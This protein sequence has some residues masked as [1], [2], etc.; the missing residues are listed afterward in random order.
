[1]NDIGF[2]ASA[3][4]GVAYLIEDSSERAVAEVQAA[5]VIAKK[6]P[7]NQF[8]A[9]EAIR[10]ACKRPLLA[11]QA[12]Y[13]YPRGGQMVE[14]AS[15]RLAEA[16]AQAWGNME[17]GIREISR[18]DG[19][20]IC[21]AYAI[22]YQSNMRDVK[23]FHVKHIR[24]TKKGPVAVKDERDIYELVANMGARRKRACILAVLPG[25]VVE[26]AIAQCKKTQESSEVP[27]AEQIR[28]M[29]AAFDEFGIKI[30]HLEKRLGHNLDA[31][32][33]TELVSLR[34]IYKSIK[35]GMADRSQFFDISNLTAVDAKSTIKELIDTKHKKV[36]APSTD[37]KK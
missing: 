26:A 35:D 29:V 20:S 31:T 36:E 6:F 8:E 11:E 9:F 1:M 32:I 14:G 24:D 25:D 12:L 7:R 3:P 33:P 4:T 16:L 17:C 21:E 22:D 37:D 15:I 18:S 23:T 10:A 28:S 5:F 19:V 27:L 2:V 13:V 30:E 34:S